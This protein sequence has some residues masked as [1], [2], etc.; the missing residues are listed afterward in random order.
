MSQDFQL[1]CRDGSRAD[2][3]EWRRCNLARVPAHA[4]V[5]RNDMHGG[6][7]FQLL[8]EGQVRRNVVPW[9]LPGSTGPSVGALR[10][11]VWR[12][13]TQDRPEGTSSQGSVKGTSQGGRDGG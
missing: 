13:S 12:N 6:L 3:T 4:V 8:N 9:E 10:A 5:I 2:V 11:K 7:I 1:L